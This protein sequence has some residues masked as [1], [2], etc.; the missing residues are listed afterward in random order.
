MIGLVDNAM[1]SW[2]A[3]GV[4]FLLLAAASLLRRRGPQWL[5][6][7]LTIVGLGFGVAGGLLGSGRLKWL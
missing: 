1:L 5:R 3:F 6:N 7:L 4:A 2:V